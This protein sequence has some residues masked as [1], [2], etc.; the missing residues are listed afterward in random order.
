M[1]DNNITM[2]NMLSSVTH[3]KGTYNVGVENYWTIS[4]VSLVCH[5]FIFRLALF[6]FEGQYFAVIGLDGGKILYE[7]FCNLK[8]IH[9]TV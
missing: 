9:F 3:I 7:D 8:W 4:I 6:S 2:R 1:I 5:R